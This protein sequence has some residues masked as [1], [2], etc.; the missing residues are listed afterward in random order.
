MITINLVEQKL[1]VKKK[2]VQKNF[3]P[4]KLL[5]HNKFLPKMFDPKEFFVQV[6]PKSILYARF[7]VQNN[8]GSNIFGFK[9]ILGPKKFWVQKKF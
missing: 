9:T 7:L 1:L 2:I 6:G 5:I 8:F 4:L 3:W